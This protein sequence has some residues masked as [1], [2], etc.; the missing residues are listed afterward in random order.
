MITPTT[1]KW[2]GSIHDEGLTEIDHGDI[3]SLRIK[4]WL[5]CIS[6]SANTHGYVFSLAAEGAW[7]FFCR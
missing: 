4:V 7:Q 3:V 5:Y 2:R 6:A 1:R